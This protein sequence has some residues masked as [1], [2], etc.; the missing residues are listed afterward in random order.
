MTNDPTQAW[1]NT[2]GR[3]PLLPKAEMIR[4]ANKRDSLEPGSDAYIKVINKI[5]EHNLRLVPNVV[6]K[7]LSKRMGYSMGSEVA[8]D[9]LQQGYLGLR[10]AA[11]KFDASRGYTFSTYAHSWIYQ[12][13]V[14]WHNS[15]DR[16]IYIPENTM[17]E[18]L[19][20]SRH[21]QPSK[22]K[23]GR[24]GDAVI[25]AATRSME[26]SS[27]D[28][29]VDDDEEGTTVADLMD[30]SNLIIEKDS[31]PDGRVELL[32]KDLM[33]ECGIRPKVQDIVIAYSKRGRI[34]LVASKVSMSPKHCQ[35]LYSE[36][37]RTMKAKVLEKQAAKEAV[38]ADRL[39]K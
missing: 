34:S 32:L 13:V 19:Y 24:I 26:V 33:A 9:L 14:R 16:S 3:F 22:S 23:N 21:G 8:T 28:K 17:T 25:A 12:S 39:N 18:V 5:C 35:N 4:L 20:R 29:R 6:S 30:S 11:E 38:I 15:H 31:A 2:A 37:V 10:R 36:A 27:I 7:Y 1:L